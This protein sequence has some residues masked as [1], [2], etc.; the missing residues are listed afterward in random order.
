MDNALIKAS[1]IVSW[2]RRWDFVVDDNDDDSLETN[3]S[4]AAIVES[5]RKTAL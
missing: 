1:I 5:T 3:V 4:I 2:Q